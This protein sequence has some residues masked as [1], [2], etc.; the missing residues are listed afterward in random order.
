MT[1]ATVISVKIPAAIAPMK[2]RVKSAHLNPAKSAGN[3]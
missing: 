1:V 2:R 3:V